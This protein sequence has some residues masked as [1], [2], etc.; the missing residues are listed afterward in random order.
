VNDELIKYYELLGVA[1]GASMQELKASHRDLAKIWHPDR[2]AH[3]PR[4]QQKAQEKLKEINEAYDQLVSG[5]LGRRT[6]RSAPANQPS[7]PSQESARRTPWKF[8]LLSALAFVILFFV[9][10]YALIPSGEQRATGSTTPGEQTQAQ[11]SEEAEDIDSAGR[12]PA[13][14][15]SRGKR[16]DQQPAREARPGSEPAFVE[17]KREVRPLPTVTVTID[18]V[19]GM[20]AT[21]SCPVKSRM[22]YPSG[23]EPRQHCNIA[24]KSAAPEQEAE[25]TRPKESRI[26]SFAK[27]LAAPAKVFGGKGKSD[28]DNR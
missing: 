11:A 24:H 7:T 3:D 13:V 22:T 6:S 8:A 19:S 25:Q 17:E 20:L 9:A 14:E 2:F 12:L 1:P 5:K 28:A 4:L 10:S 15:S 18:P 21:P 27:R 23:S 26:K 16:A